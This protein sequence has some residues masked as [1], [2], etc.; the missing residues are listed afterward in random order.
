VLLG[1]TAR[2]QFEESQRSQEHEQ[3]AP[4]SRYADD[5][6]AKMS[7]GYAEEEGDSDEDAWQ[8]TD[9]D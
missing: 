6:V 7:E 5:P 4:D 1:A 9:R 3:P 8:L 2:S